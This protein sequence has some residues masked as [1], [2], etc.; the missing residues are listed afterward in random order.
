MGSFVTGLFQNI[1]EQKKALVL[2]FVFV[3]VDEQAII[4][5]ITVRGG[6]KKLSVLNQYPQVFSSII[7]RVVGLHF[8]STGFIF[9]TFERDEPS[10]PSSSDGF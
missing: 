7:D 4:N 8:H 1:L 10:P 2:V 6:S 5:F 3:F 9:G